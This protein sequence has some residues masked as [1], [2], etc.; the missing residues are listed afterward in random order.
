MLWWHGQGRVD[1]VKSSPS[2]LRV[3]CRHTICSIARS[4]PFTP[5]VCSLPE[6]Q[7]FSVLAGK[8][9]PPPSPPSSA[10]KQEPGFP[11]L[12]MVV[13]AASASPGTAAPTGRT[14]AYTRSP[15]GIPSAHGPAA[16]ALSPRTTAAATPEAI[17]SPVISPASGRSIALL[18]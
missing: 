1:A 17:K 13:G 10:G 12:P 14:A 9:G 11:V 8:W 4:I 15:S 3:R 6:I 5:C 16:V 7:G 18:A 2:Q